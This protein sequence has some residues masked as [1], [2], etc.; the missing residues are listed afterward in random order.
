MHYV[1]NKVPLAH[2]SE[3]KE[4]SHGQL[5]IKVTSFKIA[6]LEDEQDT[7]SHHQIYSGEGV[8]FI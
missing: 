8:E 4:D 5:N 1:Q 2:R 7:D 3:S 6:D